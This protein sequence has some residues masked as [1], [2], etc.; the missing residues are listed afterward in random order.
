MATL[1]SILQAKSQD[2]TFQE[3][4]VEKGE[5]FI[6]N[7]GITGNTTGNTFT[8]TAPRN[9]IAVIE[10]WGA[11][12][13]GGRMC[14]CGAGIPGNPGAYSRKQITIS[15]GNTISGTVGR[16]CGNYDVLCCRGKSEPT[17]ICYIAA[18]TGT[19]CADGGIGGMA[20]CNGSG[21]SFF[22][23][24]V[25]AGFC[26]NQTG[27]GAGCGIVCNRRSDADIPL[28]TGGD[29]NCSGGF[30]CTTFYHCNSCCSCSTYHHVKTSPGIFSEKGGNITYTIEGDSGYSS[31]PGA[32]LHPFISALNALSRQP[33]IGQPP[34][35]CWAGSRACSCYDIVF[36]CAPILPYGIPG[37]SA[38]TCGGVRDPGMRGGHGA[39]RIKFIG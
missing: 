23:C 29:V 3:T 36:G 6:F 32:N 17:C 34:S 19:M 18:S 27:F 24:Y 26:N 16:S 37:P 33:N 12:G 35:F 39:V 11:S 21:T 10:I 22:C 28:A 25:A 14:C 38:N 31:A 1:S 5:I 15:S 13:S 8:W 30:S 2:I 7:P 20:Y 9:G 4:N